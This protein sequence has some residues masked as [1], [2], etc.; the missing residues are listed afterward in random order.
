M[1]V[2]VS[3]GLGFDKLHLKARDIE[4]KNS[5][6]VITD[7]HG[8]AHYIPK[9]MWHSIEIKQPVGNVDVPQGAT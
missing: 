3:R 8:E 7:I 5:T 1:I 9:T 6:I 2:L 4:V